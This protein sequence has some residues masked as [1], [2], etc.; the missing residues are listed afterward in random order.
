MGDSHDS[1]ALEWREGSKI[2]FNSINFSYSH[3][4]VRVSHSHN[5]IVVGEIKLRFI[6]LENVNFK[7]VNFFAR[8]CCHE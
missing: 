4:K 5:E 2:P 7:H 6:T 3:S 1:N 8:P